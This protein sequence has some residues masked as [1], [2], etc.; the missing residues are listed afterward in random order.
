M[1][2][3]SRRW[4]GEACASWPGSCRCARCA[5]WGWGG[6]RVPRR[7]STPSAPPSRILP[8]P[9][10]LANLPLCAAA[11]RDQHCRRH[12]L[13]IPMVHAHMLWQRCVGGQR[14]G[15]GRAAACERRAK[16]L[17]ASWGRML[18]RAAVT[19]CP[20]LYAEYAKPVREGLQRWYEV[21]GVG[22]PGGEGGGVAVRQR[23]GWCSPLTTSRT[24]SPCPQPA[25]EL[26]DA[27]C[28][29]ERRRRRGGPRPHLVPVSRC[30]A[31]AA[32]VGGRAGAV[33]V[34]ADHH[35]SPPPPHLPPLCCTA[36]ARLTT[37][38]RRGC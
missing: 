8:T 12:P 34:F 2:S 16:G 25:P 24:R 35:P 11:P 27:H 31:W 29:P 4:W 3:P 30:R 7:V 23:A 32:R 6:A 17:L 33:C 21:S 14:A 1:W 22:G 37:T 15:E 10:T 13:C 18:S 36:A 9:H 26:R 28:D 19:A 5:V 20:L 38:P